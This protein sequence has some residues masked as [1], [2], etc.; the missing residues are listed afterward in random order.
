[1]APLCIHC[2]GIAGSFGNQLVPAEWQQGAKVEP[3][4][5]HDGRLHEDEGDK[6]EAAN[7]PDVQLGRVRH[8]RSDGAQRSEHGRQSQEGRYAQANACYK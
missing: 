6:D 2:P 3:D 5:D 8:R 7:D 1:M 4:V